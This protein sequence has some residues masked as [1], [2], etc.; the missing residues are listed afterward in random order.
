MADILG[1]ALLYLSTDSSALDAGIDKAKEG[2]GS[3]ESAFTSASSVI[4]GAFAAIGISVG[5]KEVLDATMEQE[6]VTK[7]L[8][9]AIKA[10]GSS[11][12]FTSEQLTAQAAAI[13]RNTTYSDEA[14]ITLQSR[15]MA[16]RNIHGEVFER[17]TKLT[18]DFATATGTDAEGAV[19]TLGM[20]LNDPIEGMNRLKRAGVDVNDALKAQVTEMTNAGNVV[21]AQ[22]L[23]LNELEKSYGG[24][25]AAARDTLSGALQSLRN[26]IGDAMEGSSEFA[27]TLKDFVNFVNGQ[28]PNIK[29]VFESTFAA[30][31]VAVEQAVESIFYLSQGLSRLV[32][33]DFKGAMDA[34]GQMP[35][36]T[37]T[38]GDAMQAAADTTEKTSQAMAEAKIK[39]DQLAASAATSAGQIAEASAQAKAAHDAEIAATLEKDRVAQQSAMEEANRNAQKAEIV[40]AQILAQ[41]QNEEAMLVAK[42]EHLNAEADLFFQQEEERLAKSALTF[43]QYNQALEALEV[44][45]NARM[46]AIAAADAKARQDLE[47]KQNQQRLQAA[48]GIAGNLLTILQ[49]TNSKQKDLIK[50]AAI[51]QATIDA[52]L[53]YGR[54]LGSAPPPFNMILAG[55]ALAAGLSNVARITAMQAGG[56]FRAGQTLM[57]GEAG[58]EIITPRR[59]GSVIP[60]DQI[61]AGG[62]TVFQNTFVLPGLEAARDPATSR[63]ILEILATE[64]ERGS[65]EASRAARTSARLAERTGDLAA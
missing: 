43:Q 14:I 64:M 52:F 7:L 53:A 13:Q 20:A 42:H 59:S 38:F 12:G 18:L 45:K 1:E 32:T 6:R 54:A 49:N 48:S 51:A 24:A 31:K 15:L 65:A 37:K 29:I 28:V 10:T 8:D 36:L 26:S 4:G 58:P 57:V 9:A 46:A 27:T 39:Q 16:F 63:A 5:I 2:A 19:R 50:A 62:G 30:I 21:G 17:A 3:L 22:N 33:G 25:A 35:D 41:G 34:F 23:L 11:A 56:D 47:A 61:G 40:S 44:Q 55:T 60:N